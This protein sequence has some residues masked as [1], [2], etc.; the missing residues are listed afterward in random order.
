MK[1]YTVETAVEGT[2]K[3]FYIMDGETLDIAVD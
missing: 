3:Y 2:T 1:R